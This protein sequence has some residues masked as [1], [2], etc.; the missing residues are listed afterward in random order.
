MKLIPRLLLSLLPLLL[1]SPAAFAVDGVILINQATAA[2]GLP[3]CPNGSG[4]LIFICNPGSYRLSG[5][6]TVSTAD[7]G[8]VWL[9]P[10]NTTL[11]LNGFTISGPGVFAHPTG[12]GVYS[13]SNAN[14]TVVNG[15]VTGFAY[16]VL[17]SRSANA[18]V[19]QIRSSLNNATGIQVD[20]GMVQDC[21]VDGTPVGIQIGD[22]TV[23]RCRINVA[24]T[25]I[26]SFNGF[27]VLILQNSI[28]ATSGF[29]PNNAISINFNGTNGAYGL[30]V[31]NYGP[32]EGGTSMG[33]NVCGNTKC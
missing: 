13:D 22:G 30:N 18:Y 25:G 16:G 19:H 11:D 7:G 9:G 10:A 4:F 8:G 33:N 1:L 14:I 29:G 6:L 32:V 5:N 17:I 21:I 31:L 23:E 2:T 24:G 3:G 12:I 20:D 27:A 15:T 28:A 26:L